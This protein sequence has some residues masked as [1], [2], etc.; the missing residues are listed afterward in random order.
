MPDGLTPGLGQVEIV[1]R[2]DLTGTE[3]FGKGDGSGHGSPGHHA[4]KRQNRRGCAWLVAIPGMGQDTINCP[5]AIGRL[6]PVGKDAVQ[7]VLMRNAVRVIDLHLDVVG[8]E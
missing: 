5:T 2:D 7:H 4:R 3:A 8:S 1:N 6:H